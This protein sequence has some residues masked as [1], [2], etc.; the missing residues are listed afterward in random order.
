MDK[1]PE[2]KVLSVKVTPI[3]TALLWKNKQTTGKQQKHISQ[4]SY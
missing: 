1:D 3:Y 2:P 4:H